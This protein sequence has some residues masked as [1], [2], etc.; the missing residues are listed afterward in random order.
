LIIN[1]NNQ[2]EARLFDL[3]NSNLVIQTRDTV[4]KRLGKRCCWR[5]KEKRLDLCNLCFSGE[6]EERGLRKFSVI[7]KDVGDLG[8]GCAQINRSSKEEPFYEYCITILADGTSIEGWTLKDNKDMTLFS[9]NGEKF[10]YCKTVWSKFL[11]ENLRTQ[12]DLFINDILWGSVKSGDYLFFNK[13]FFCKHLVRWNS[14]KMWRPNKA[15]LPIY[16]APHEHLYDFFSAIF[17]LATLQFLWKKSGYSGDL[18]IPKDSCDID[19]SEFM[20]LFITNIMFRSMFFD[21]AYIDRTG[22]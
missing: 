8:F 22:G 5:T 4:L 11:W 18:I 7:S 15:S 21:L 12:W 19:N 6:I 2:F 3:T 1:I 13:Y 20:A 17:K 9:V 14:L 16:L 10:G